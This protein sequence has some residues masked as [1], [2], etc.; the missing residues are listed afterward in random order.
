[1]AIPAIPTTVM[2]EAEAVLKVAPKGTAAPADRPVLDLYSSF[3]GAVLS[4][5]YYSPHLVNR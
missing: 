4:P 5:S 2:A 1:M 3:H